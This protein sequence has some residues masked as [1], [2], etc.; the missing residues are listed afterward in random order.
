MVD[1]KLHPDD[2]RVLLPV[3]S[4]LDSATGKTEWS[5][6]GGG[7]AMAITKP[8]SNT[9]QVKRA[10]TLIKSDAKPLQSGYGT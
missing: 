9:E 5:G 3:V 4:K 6:G 10:L 7:I 1:V 2:G 8:Q